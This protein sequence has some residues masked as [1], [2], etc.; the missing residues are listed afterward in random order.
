MTRDYNTIFFWK[1]HTYETSQH[2][3]PGTGGITGTLTQEKLDKENEYQSP[4]TLTQEKLDKEN[5]YQSSVT[6]QIYD[7]VKKPECLQ[8]SVK[9]KL[10][11]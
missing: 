7:S 4:G 6:H 5:E 10:Y 2:S 11:Y 8:A 1:F 3:I 9:Y